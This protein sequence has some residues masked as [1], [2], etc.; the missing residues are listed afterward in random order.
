MAIDYNTSFYDTGST[1]PTPPNYDDFVL[2]TGDTMTGALILDD[3]SEAASQDWVTAQITAAIPTFAAHTHTIADISD[4]GVTGAILMAAPT[5][6][7]ARSTLGLG[8]AATSASSAFAAASH[9]HTQSDITGLVSAL[10]GK[11]DTGHTHAYTDITG[12]S[13]TVVSFLGAADEAAAQTALG[14][15]SAAAED[16]S[17]FSLS[18]HT[19]SAAD[20][21]SGVFSAARL[22]T[23][24]ATSSVFLRGDGVWSA[25]S[26]AS[27]G[28]VTSVAISGGTT[29]LTTS[30]GPITSSGTVTLAGTLAVANGGTGATSAGA[31]LTALGAAAASHSHA[32]SDV[33][34]GTM[35]TARLGSGT[36]NSSSFL[37][38]DQTWVKPTAVWEYALSDES[39]AISATGTVLNTRARHAMTVS[40]IRISVG[41]A[42]TSGLVTV[43]V[44]K[45]GTTVFSTKITIDANEKTSVTAATAFALSGGSL[46]F[47]DDDEITASIDVTG[48]GAKALKLAIIGTYG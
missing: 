47:A 35:A 48:T 13:S 23:G 22:G 20:I 39:T 19:H 43:D 36:A 31:A 29:G 32:A 26:G 37:R 10:A 27:G 33:T 7:S 25:V 45:N 12:M 30:G 8:S 6:S 21:T 14:L 18:T 40:D 9:T 44:K 46:S 24:S 11:S 1:P 17:Y 15:G 42:S 5:A 16:A 4:A 41:T 38:G 34:S 2:T 3:A 28:T